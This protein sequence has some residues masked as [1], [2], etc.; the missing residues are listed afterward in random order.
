MNLSTG[1][2]DPYVKFSLGKKVVYKSRTIL[3]NLNPKWDEQL[4]IPVEEL[5]RPVGVKVRQILRLFSDYTYTH[6]STLQ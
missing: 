4:S 1:T 3:K 6:V 2:S 5:S